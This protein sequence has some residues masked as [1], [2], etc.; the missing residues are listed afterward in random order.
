MRPTAVEH[1][2]RLTVRR[3]RR[4]PGRKP[5]QK[6]STAI[7]CYPAS[8]FS[9]I[10]SMVLPNSTWRAHP[11]QIGSEYEACETF[12][13]LTGGE[14]VA[15]KRYAL[16]HIGHS[17]YDESTVFRFQALGDEPVECWWQDSEPGNLCAT[18]FRLVAG[19]AGY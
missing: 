14:F 3:G 15:G 13:G 2:Q 18:R 9:A 11:L 8:Q 16:R 4:R 12:L 1:L 5:A 7:D 19:T 10:N 6:R 17:H